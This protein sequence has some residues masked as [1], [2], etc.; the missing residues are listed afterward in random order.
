MGHA[1]TGVNEDAQPRFDQEILLETQSPRGELA[2]DRR[3]DDR[4]V[5]YS[6]VGSASELARFLYPC[7]A[8]TLQVSSVA[9]PQLPE[10]WGP[11]REPESEGEQD[12]PEAGAPR[13]GLEVLG[14]EHSKPA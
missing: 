4:I 14:P 6:R 12:E 9:S 3:V 11:D 1:S 7:S 2:S 5:S 8:T 10:I 13:I